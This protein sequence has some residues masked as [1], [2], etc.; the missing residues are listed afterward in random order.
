MEQQPSD[1][2]LIEDIQRDIKEIKT[3]FPRDEE[4]SP[5]Y[6]EHRLF[7][8]DELDVKESNKVKKDRVFSNVITWV[9]IGTLTLVINHLLPLLSKV[10]N[11]GG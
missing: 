9:V 11:G 7:H 8:R 6:V 2:E 1:R 4:G 10:L 3:A 5:N